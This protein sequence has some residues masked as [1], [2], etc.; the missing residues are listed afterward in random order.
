[1]QA[2]MQR[3]VQHWQTLLHTLVEQP[4]VRLQELE[5]LSADERDHLLQLSGAHTTVE[6]PPLSLSAQVAVQAQRIPDTIAAVQADEQLSY[7][8]LQQQAHRLAQILQQQGVRPEVPVALC[9]PRQLPLLIST[10]A[11]VAAG[12]VC[13]P[14]DPNY[15]P[16]RLQLMLTQSGA[17]LLLSEPALAA[18]LPEPLPL[19]LSL[20]D[21]WLQLA[22]LPDQA[23]AVAWQPQQLLYLLFTSGST[24]VPKGVGLPHEAMSHLL[25]WQ[26]QHLGLQQPARTLQ[27]SSISFDIYWNEAFS[28]WLCGGTLHLLEQAGPLDGQALVQQLEQQAIERVFLPFSTLRLLAEAALLIPQ[29]ELVL[30]EVLCTA[31]ALQVSPVL[32]R[33]FAQV[34]GCA[35]INEYGPSETHVVSALELGHQQDDWP[36]APSIGV[37]ISQTQLYVL[38]ARWRLV[39]QGQVG[40]LYIGGV[41]LARGY[42]QRPDLT[43]ERFVP[44]PFAR[45]AGQRLYRT[46]DRVRWLPQG[47]LQYLGRADGQIKLRGY[48][49][50]LGEIEVVLGQH[51]AIEAVAVR[52]QE[53]GGEPRLLAY[54]VGRGSERLDWAQVRRWLGERVPGYMQPAGM[55]QVEALP[56]TSSGKVDR[57]ALPS[58]E[59]SVQTGQAG[60]VAREGM[61]QVVQQVW[62]QVLQREE[63]GVQEEF[64]A[65]G[66]HSLLAM[67]VQVRLQQV[68]GRSI[69][70]RTLFEAPT[71]AQLAQR[72]LQEQQ[73]QGGMRVPQLRPRGRGQEIPLSFGQQRLWF[74]DQLEP[75]NLTYHIPIVVRLRGQLDRGAW[76]KAFSE[77]V[78]RHESLRTTFPEREGRP[79]Q[80]I[81]PQIIML[82]PIVD[83]SGL[84]VQIAEERAVQIA[85]QAIERPFDLISGPLLRCELLGLSSQEHILILCLHHIVAD[86]WSLSVLLRELV[87]CYHALRQGQQPDLPEL[88]V[89]YADYTLWQQQ[90]LQGEM[91]EHLLSYWRGQMFGAPP[92]LELPTDHPRTLTPTY[93]GDNFICLLPQSV[94][95]Q[96]QQLSRTEGV[97]LFMTLLAAFLVVLSAVSGQEDIVVG[98][99]IANR[100]QVELEQLIGFFINTLVLRTNLSGN[101][102]FRELLQ[103][104]RETCLGAYAHQELPFE[105]LVEALQPK[106]QQGRSP[107]FL[108]ML[109]LQN[110][111]AIL[112]EF[113]EI[114][115]SIVPIKEETAKFDITISVTDTTEGLRMNAEYNTALFEQTS[116][117]SLLKQYQ[118]VLEQAVENPDQRIQHF[119]LDE[120]QLYLS[121]DFS[122][123]LEHI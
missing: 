73:E 123:N 11:I 116:I 95:K 19:V 3:F 24:G 114:A 102:T 32:R 48:R 96:V 2:S 53:S 17:T 15:P 66:G 89:Q 78:Q 83:L 58:F 28:T 22:T 101:P 29:H 74:L 9:L 79:V 87:Q 25:H 50:E 40:D 77:V 37:P 108:V 88:P 21:L 4:Q 82:L 92:A 14:L 97:T 112:S 54:V 86:G 106:R 69:A 45:Q 100:Q 10:L 67:Q 57:R 8:F 115:L 99:P 93:H 27:A 91:L 120:E 30:R 33:F 62:Q 61:E 113:D 16:A 52:V 109:Q 12:G 59:P 118:V 107:F 35:L 81:A 64:F 36:E 47:E 26:G 23:P 34:P 65:I 42:V 49:I 51:P 39:P 60:R 43:A 117:K 46:G 94:G 119:A 80:S 98:S 104:V 76:H 41:S 55:L 6:V 5:L 63:V 75:G 71:I 103:R 20:A 111:P 122:G 44:D 68:L 105:L 72:L 90:W 110:T 84:E 70:L 85:Q 121:D 1:E 56:L 38:D 18:H 31:E 7:A 13:V